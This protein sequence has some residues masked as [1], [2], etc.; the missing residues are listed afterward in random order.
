MKTFLYITLAAALTC[1]AAPTNAQRLVPPGDVPS[2]TRLAQTQ[3]SFRVNEL[4]EQVRQLNGKVEELNFLL[5]QLQEKIRQMEEDTELRLQEIEDKR[6][7][8]GDS[9]KP[10]ANLKTEGPERLGKPDTSEAASPSDATPAN[11][12]TVLPPIK[13]AD[14]PR[15]LGTLTFDEEGNVID[16]K[17]D[18]TRLS[19]LPGIFNDGIDGGAEAAEFG[20]TPKEVLA[21]GLG[22]MRVRDFKRAQQAFSAFLKAWPNDPEVGK[23]KFH[24]GK[25]YFWQKE[26]YRAADSHLDAHNNYPEA[27][28][29]PDNLLALGLALAGLNQREVACATYA[30]VLKQYLEAEPRLGNQ[31]RDEQAA[32]KC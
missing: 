4:E 26:Y 19:G 23:A 8:L 6:S 9:E 28:T 24:L 16:S 5:L 7:Q 10:V 2:V 18:E 11:N 32:T 22:D 12:P 17:S 15:A 21:A 29:A 14:E 3:D 13:Q 1:L 30:E 25:S 20:A 31:V 27:E